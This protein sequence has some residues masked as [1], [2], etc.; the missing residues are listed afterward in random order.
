MRRRAA[1]GV[2][3]FHVMEHVDLAGRPTGKV[4]VRW[5]A[6]DKNSA[7]RRFHDATGLDP[8]AFKPQSPVPA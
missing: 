8:T 1:Q 4:A 7:L 3:N 6:D 5:A 2:D